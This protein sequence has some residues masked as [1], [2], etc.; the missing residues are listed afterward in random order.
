[1]DDSEQSAALRERRAHSRLSCRGLALLRILP[2]GPVIRGA[3][4]NLSQGGCLIECEKAIPAEKSGLVEVQLD[5]GDFRLLLLGAIRHIEGDTMVGIQFVDISSRKQQQVLY[6]IGELHEMER[7]RAY[8][9]MEL[10]SKET[11]LDEF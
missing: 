5:V 4:H 7:Q 8:Q 10:K 6:L 9:V 3:V 1:M 2:E 11:D